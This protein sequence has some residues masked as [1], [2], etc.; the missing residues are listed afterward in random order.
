[1]H[2]VLAA[3]LVGVHRHLEL[4]L[5]PAHH[6]QVG[7]ARLHHHHIGAFRQVQRDF[8][9]RLVGIGRVHLVG[10]FV[11]LAQVR[12]RAHRV[13][14]RAVIGGG[15]LGGVGHDAGVR[16][17]VAF[18]GLADLADAAVHHVRGRHHVGAGLG[19]GHRLL[20]QG[21][22]G[23]VVKHIAVLVE[24]AVLAVGGERVQGHVGD[25]AH[26][27]H[28][29]FDRPGGALGQ[30]VRVPGFGAVQAFHR[31][32]RDRKQGHGRDPQVRQLACFLAQQVHGHALDAGHRGHRF[33]V[34]FAVEDEH[35]VDQVVHGEG[36]FAHQAAGEIVLAH[37]AHAA[38]RPGG[39]VERHGPN[40]S[41]GRDNEWE[42]Q[43][44]KPARQG[45]N[46]PAPRSIM[47]LL[48]HKT[49][50]MAS[51]MVI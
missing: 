9:Q 8:V 46:E 22:D 44:T 28:R 37:A 26:L 32:R 23:D 42:T 30:P 4:V 49:I 27:R 43:F 5:H 47:A 33:G 7:H 51:N 6:V 20:D 12:R 25:H 34:V 50:I 48:C 36:V 11:R 38:G 39:T 19:V 13:A 18:Q 29:L 21:G 14:E 3:H 35:R 1:M 2:G 31:H 40:L 45:E 41:M 24:D 15:V 16:K 10:A 17:A